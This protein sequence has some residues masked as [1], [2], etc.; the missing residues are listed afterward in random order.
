[1][2]TTETDLVH[3]LMLEDGGLGEDFDGDALPRLNVPR[4]LDLGEG[5]LP[6]RPFHLILPHL[7]SHHSTL[8]TPTTPPPTLHR[9][10][11]YHSELP[12]RPSP[13]NH[14]PRPISINFEPKKTTKNCRKIA[15]RWGNLQFQK[16]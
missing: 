5:P 9:P 6:N 12:Q 16:D 7:L 2:I 4:E 15:P 13:P 3:H 11:C 1:M 10:P 14:D 8:P